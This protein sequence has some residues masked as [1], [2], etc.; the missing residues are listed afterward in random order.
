[1]DYVQDCKETGA[2]HEHLSHGCGGEAGGQV[3]PARTVRHR[4]YG[5]GGREDSADHLRL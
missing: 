3:M 1:M 5:R 4:A 2:Y